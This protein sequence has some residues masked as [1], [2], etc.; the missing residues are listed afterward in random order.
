MT[1][2]APSFN[3][4]GIPLGRIGFEVVNLNYP[5]KLPLTAMPALNADGISAGCPSRPRTGPTSESHD[6]CFDYGGRSVP[7]KMRMFHMMALARE[8]GM[9]PA[10]PQDP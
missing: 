5:G 6:C 2:E 7:F 4:T 1:P 3:V 8:A 10:L 9:K